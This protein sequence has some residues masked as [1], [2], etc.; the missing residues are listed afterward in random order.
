MRTQHLHGELKQI[1]ATLTPQQLDQSP[2]HTGI[3]LRSDPCEHFLHQQLE[4]PK[5]DII[6]H[7][8]VSNLIGCCLATLHQMN[9]VSHLDSHARDVWNEVRGTLEVG[10]GHCNVPACVLRSH[11]VS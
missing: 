11:A 4:R 10:R 8:P 3:T 1:L 2:R 5:V 7:Q 9:E 6:V